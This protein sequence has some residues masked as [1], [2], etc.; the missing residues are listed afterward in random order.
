MDKK[1]TAKIQKLTPDPIPSSRSFSDCIVMEPEEKEVILKKGKIFAVFDVRGSEELDNP[2][3]KN[4]VND[5][6]HDSYYQSDNISPI[7]SLEKAIIDVNDRVTKITNESIKANET[8]V[9][10]NIVASAL[11][12]N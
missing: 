10:F 3:I 6:L 2:L 5:I 12:G 8:Q 11:W 9:E 4:I 7:Q 1:L